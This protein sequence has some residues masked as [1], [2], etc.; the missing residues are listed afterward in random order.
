[1]RWS[2]LLLGLSLFSAGGWAKKDKKP[3]SA[4]DRFDDF[5]AKSRSATP[6]KIDDAS[7]KKLTATPRDYSSGILLTAMDPRFGCQLC[8]EFQPEWELL[9]K[10]WMKGD[11]KGESRMIFATLDFNDGRETFMSMG[12]QT[13]PV[14]LFFPATAGPHAVAAPE[15]LR[16]DFTSGPQTAEQVRNWLARHLPDRPHPIVKRPFDYLGWFTSITAFLGAA[17]FTYVCWDYISLVLWSRKIWAAC[18]LI[19]ILLFTSGQ[20]FNHIRGV[21][22]VAGDGRGG[23]SYFAAGFQNQFGMETQLVAA[24]YGTLA[25]AIISLGVTAPRIAD[26]KRQQLTILAWS[27]ILFL[28]YGLLLSVFRIKNGGYPF[29]LPPFM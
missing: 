1:M 13:A 9:S 22:Y 20:M 14:L 7:Y 18:S 15:P 4:V 21:P 2:S 26:P 19:A 17:T 25:F 28:M 16:Y 3:Q 29:A 6:I 23:I 12:L 5:H 27:G 10:S 8:R 24:M 11:R